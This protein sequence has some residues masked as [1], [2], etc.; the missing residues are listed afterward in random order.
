[1]RSGSEND[2][3]TEAIKT[4]TVNSSLSEVVKNARH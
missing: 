4:R 3:R 2:E 1:M